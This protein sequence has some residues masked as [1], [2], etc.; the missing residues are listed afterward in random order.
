M[1]WHD[2]IRLSLLKQFLKLGSLLS[3]EDSRARYNDGLKIHSNVPHPLRVPTSPLLNNYFSHN[4]SS[5]AL[6]PNTGCHHC[7]TLTPMQQV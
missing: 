4:I 6:A 3:A 7:W 5:P 2:V 1:P